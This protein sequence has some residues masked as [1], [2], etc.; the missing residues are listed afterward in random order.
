MTRDLPDGEELTTVRAMARRG[1]LVEADRRAVAL[2]N[3]TPA[4][5]PAR[6][7]AAHLCGSIAF[8]QGRIEE[9][10]R[11]FE[12]AI[13]IA[14]G[15]GDAELTARATT[16]LGSIAHL[17]GKDTLALSL[18]RS[19]MIAWRGLGHAAGVAQVSHNLALVF[20][21]QGDLGAAAAAATRAVR[22]ARESGDTALE[23]TVRLGSVEQALAEGAIGRATVELD[24]ARRCAEAARDGLGQAEAARLEG[25]IALAE[26]RF[27]T[28]L[29]RA[30]LG[31]RR[32]LRL[33]GLQCAS[34]CAELAFQA[35]RMLRRVRS[36]QRFY[37]S[38]AL[39]YARLSARPALRR[40][41][42]SR[43]A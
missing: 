39:G 25:A 10:E 26:G 14:R 28:A 31:Q 34:E 22:A 33:G 27:A 16:N 7:E 36:A 15:A 13:S 37:H 18:Y 12:E 9:A 3:R 19:A 2:R 8:E 23:G 42:T 17:R 11:H 1:D 32:A 30:G 4:G 43:P 6:G 38:A 5:S 40:L 24:H 41:E 20:R 21:E 29:R 35:S